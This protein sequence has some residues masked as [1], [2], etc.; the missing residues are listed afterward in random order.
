[1]AARIGVEEGCAPAPPY[2]GGWQLGGGLGERV[3]GKF[4][5]LLLEGFL[6]VSPKGWPTGP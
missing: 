3:G 4:P 5:P 6:R 1:M 2:I